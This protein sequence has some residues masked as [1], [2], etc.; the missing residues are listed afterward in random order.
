MYV[1]VRDRG[2][3]QSC[4]SVVLVMFFF[5]QNVPKRGGVLSIWLTYVVLTY[6]FYG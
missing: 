3:N 5:H 1:Q 6:I 4:T 2:S